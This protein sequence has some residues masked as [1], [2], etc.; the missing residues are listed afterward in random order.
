MEQFIDG[1]DELHGCGNYY[2][3][4]NAMKDESQDDDLVIALALAWSEIVDGCTGLPGTRP[5]SVTAFT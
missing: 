1:T 5:C 4:L 2:A 3:A